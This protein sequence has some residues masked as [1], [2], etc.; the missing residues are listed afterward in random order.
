MKLNRVDVI[1]WHRSSADNTN[2]HKAG[3]L[4]K[5]KSPSRLKNIAHERD[6]DNVSVKNLRATEKGQEK[7]LHSEEAT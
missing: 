1:H 3:A 2:A 4:E 5:D 6:G 7:C